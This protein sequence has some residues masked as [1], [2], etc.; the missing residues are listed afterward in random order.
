MLIGMDV[1]Q[2]VVYPEILKVSS[3]ITA[4]YSIFGWLLYGQAHGETQKAKVHLTLHSISEE[5]S[6]QLL[7]AFW[8]V[9]EV[10]T[11]K[12]YYSS[13]EQ[14]ALDHYEKTT[15]KTSSGMYQVKLPQCQDAPTL[16]ESCNQAERR[17]VSTEMALKRKGKWESFQEVVNDYFISR[18]AE[19]V[20]E[21]DIK[22][23]MSNVFYLPMHGVT[24]QASTTTKLRTVFDGSTATTT[25]VSLN[26]ILLPG[27]NVYS[28]L[29]DI[30]LR[31]RLHEVG[32]T[33]DVSKMFR[34]IELHPSIR[35]L[36]RFLWKA[37]SGSIV[38]CRMTRLTF[39]VTS[40]PFIAAQTLR[41]IATDNAKLYPQAAEVVL[42]N[43]Y[44]D[45][46]LTG[47]ESIEEASEL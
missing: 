32:L 3:S 27:P 29:P 6:D 1:Y 44:V 46:R 21:E 22:K 2:S 37:E 25:G 30:L 13:E 47:A 36:H 38:D 7:K 14:L 41:R 10:H 45:D 33:A 16:G 35:D 12:D 42:K 39:G 24:K 4:Q 23:P 31:F 20:P 40:S 26:D 8:E 9:E 15:V 19:L 18:Y 43:F 5:G 17:L 28:P 34:M 11:P